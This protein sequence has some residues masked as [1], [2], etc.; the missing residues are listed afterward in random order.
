MRFLLKKL[1][2]ILFLI[3]SIF[4]SSLQA[5]DKNV[6]LLILDKS[7][8]TKYQINFSNNYVFRDITL[9]LVSCNSLEFDKYIDIIALIKIK[10]KG[11][12]FIGWFFKYTDELNVYSNKIYEI[13]LL[14]CTN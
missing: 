11:E 6:S 2:I 12:N 9:E 7:S 10:N 13:S 4:F 5:Q 8:S 3:N 1:L 14:S